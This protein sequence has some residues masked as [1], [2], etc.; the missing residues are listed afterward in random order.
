MA[1]DRN[2]PGHQRGRHWPGLFRRLV[3]DGQNIPF[4]VLKSCKNLAEKQHSPLH[5]T[6]KLY[7]CTETAVCRLAHCASCVFWSYLSKEKKLIGYTWNPPGLGCE[8]GFSGKVVPAVAELQMNGPACCWCA[9]RQLVL[10][11]EVINTL[12]IN[13]SLGGRGVR[14]CS[15]PYTAE[16]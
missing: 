8:I 2:V 4:L 3:L 14:R 12:K 6:P 1:K 13:K 16:L 5:L 10:P 11:G 15:C 9:Q 7:R